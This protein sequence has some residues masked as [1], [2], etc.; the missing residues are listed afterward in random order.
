MPSNRGGSFVRRVACRLF[1]C[2]CSRT[3]SNCSALTKAGTGISIHSSRGRSSPLTC[4]FANFPGPARV[5]W[6]SA[7]DPSP[8]C[9]KSP[10][11][12]RPDC[13]EWLQSPSGPSTA[14]P[15]ES[16]SLAPSGCAQSLRCCTG[17][18]ES[19]QTLG[20]PPRPPPPGSR[21]TAR[22]RA[23][24]HVAVSV[25]R[26]REHAPRPV[27]RLDPLATPGSLVLGNHAPH[28]DQQ[29]LLRSL[30]RRRLH[31]LARHPAARQLLQ[32]QHLLGVLPAERV[33]SPSVKVT[34]FCQGGSPLA[35]R[36]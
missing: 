10:S 29:T 3:C 28:L 16:E 2:S 6:P 5:A 20:A 22:P 17:P 11:R 25:G 12:G 27:P 19:C 30:R 34:G 33:R 26:S 24:L 7:S 9:R 14:S 21:S 13:A 31:E 15:C 23:T 8:S 32:Q 4:W 35:W 36:P 1:A 18:A